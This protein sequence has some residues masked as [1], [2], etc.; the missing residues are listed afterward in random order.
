MRILS[1]LFWERFFIKN[2]PKHFFFFLKLVTKNQ[3]GRVIKMK[4]PIPPKTEI[5]R[6]RVVWDLGLVFSPLLL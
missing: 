3:T 6:A 5:S 1:F 4:S 2:V